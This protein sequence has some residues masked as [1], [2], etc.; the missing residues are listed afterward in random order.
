MASADNG[1]A[2][3]RF[4]ALSPTLNQKQERYKNLESENFNLKMRLF[5][6]QQRNDPPMSPMTGPR[7]LD[8][9]A[10]GALGGE[11]ADALR[12]E[13]NES[14]LT[15]QKQALKLEEYGVVLARAKEAIERLR[16]EASGKKSAE[17]EMLPISSR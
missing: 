11:E 10:A 13:L 3:R 14:N 12:K 15:V 5:E 16:E 2:A 17:V 9:S 7:F 6:L 8:A 1:S 4:D